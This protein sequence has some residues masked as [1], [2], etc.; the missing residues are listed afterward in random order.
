MGTNYGTH[1]KFNLLNM[2]N[3]IIKSNY[4]PIIKDNIKEGEYEKI[5]IIKFFKK[6]FLFKL[7]ELL[8]KIL[9]R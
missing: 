2:G 6:K 7:K 1:S 8:K 5:Q 9:F 3:V 4:K